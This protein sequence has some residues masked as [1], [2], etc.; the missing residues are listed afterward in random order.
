M[1]KIIFPLLVCAILFAGESKQ[2]GRLGPSLRG[3]ALDDRVGVASLIT[4]LKNAPKNIDLMA[5]D[6]R[7]P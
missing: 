4:L 2:F 7:Q 3:K 6:I 5:T 1:K